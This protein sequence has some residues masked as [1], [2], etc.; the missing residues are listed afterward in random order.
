[1][2]YSTCGKE[3]NF[4]HSFGQKLKRKT[5]NYRCEVNFKMSVRPK[6]GV[7]LGWINFS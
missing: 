5:V 2:E 6:Y 3:G 4:T 1:M 7:G